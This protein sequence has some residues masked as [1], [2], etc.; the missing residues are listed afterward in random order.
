MS[1]LEHG[2]GL[3]PQQESGEDFRQKLK[4][5]QSLRYQWDQ[6][7]G[8]TSKCEHVEDLKSQKESI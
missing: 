2:A 7:E 5:E 1:P 4:A 3:K 6:V 8:L